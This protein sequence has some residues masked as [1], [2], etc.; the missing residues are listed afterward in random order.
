IGEGLLRLSIGL[1]DVEDLVAD[2]AQALANPRRCPSHRVRPASN[3]HAWWSR[4]A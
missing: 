1:E 3:A 4:D 2:L